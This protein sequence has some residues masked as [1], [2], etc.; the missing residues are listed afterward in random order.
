LDAST[1]PSNDEVRASIQA[2]LDQINR[3]FARVE[4]VKKFKI[5]PR[6]FSQECGEL[7]PSM[8]V[9]RNVVAEKYASEV[10]SLYEG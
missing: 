1:L 8:K 3:K 7:T 10:E 6:D 9:K 5:L 4:Q 2:H